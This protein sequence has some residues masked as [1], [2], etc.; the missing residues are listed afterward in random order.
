VFTADLFFV[1]FVLVVRCLLVRGAGR[2]LVGP[3]PL[4]VSSDLSRA[5]QERRGEGEGGKEGGKDGAGGSWREGGKEEGGG[6][7]GREFDPHKGGV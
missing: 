4:P 5:C 7:G 6:G 2:E 3:A 1:F